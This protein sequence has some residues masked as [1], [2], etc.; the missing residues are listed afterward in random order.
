MDHSCIPSPKQTKSYTLKWNVYSP[1]P[2]NNIYRKE[3]EVSRKENNARNINSLWMQREYNNQSDCRIYN[4]WPLPAMRE[5]FF[6]KYTSFSSK[7]KPK[8]H[9]NQ[10]TKS[11]I[12]NKAY[13]APHRWSCWQA[14]LRQNHFLL[15]GFRWWHCLW[16]TGLRRWHHFLP[17]A[18]V[19]FSVTTQNN[20]REKNQ[21]I[22]AK[23]FIKPDESTTI[24][25]TKS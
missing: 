6:Q 13:L 1:I 24:Q 25:S 15:T 19:W 23:K 2:M 18:H 8:T 3:Q 11:G 22:N 14:V 12:W 10:N 21:V 17:K 4:S 9:K 16:L 5:H 7:S 20:R